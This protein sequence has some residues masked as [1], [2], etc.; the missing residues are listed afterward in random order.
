MLDAGFS[1]CY[2]TYSW[3]VNMYCDQGNKDAVIGLPDELSRKGLCVDISVYRALIRRLSKLDKI[4]S[5]ETIFN[6]MQAK[7]MKGDSV[8]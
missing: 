5:A 8:V 2:S 3:L 7:G 4:V 1:P 6:L